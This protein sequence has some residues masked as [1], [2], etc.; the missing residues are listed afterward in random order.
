MISRWSSQLP[1]NGP[2]GRWMAREGSGNL[3]LALEGVLGEQPT[4]PRVRPVLGQPSR[5]EENACYHS[6]S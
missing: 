5:Q 2:Y 1:G 4:V 3:A 6:N